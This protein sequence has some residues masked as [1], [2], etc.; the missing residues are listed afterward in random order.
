MQLDETLDAK[1]THGQGT[2]NS[3]PLDTPDHEQPGMLYGGTGFQPVNPWKSPDL[4]TQKR[5]LPHLQAREA[6][7]FVTFRCRKGVTLPETARE[8]TLSAIRYWDGKRIDLD[9][10]VVMPDHV[11]AMF[12]VTDAST[13]SEIMHSIKSFSSNQVNRLIGR[14]GQL[15]LDETFDHIIRHELE[16]EEK[17]GY[18]R[19][20]PVKNNLAASPEDYSWL[21]VNSHR[22]EACA[23]CSRSQ[24]PSRVLL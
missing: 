8:L 19:Q 17:L 10:A 21:Y 4:I 23:T 24:K 22:L 15:W 13:L 2:T 12:R 1:G 7:Y 5:N 20:N 3:Q 9:G 11:H 6:T 14:K 18:I 16:W